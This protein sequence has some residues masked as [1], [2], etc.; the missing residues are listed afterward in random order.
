MKRECKVKTVTIS[1]LIKEFQRN[2]EPISKEYALKII[3]QLCTSKAQLLYSIQKATD[4][5]LGIVPD[6]ELLGQK[7][8]D[9]VLDEGLKII[10][11]TDEQTIEYLITNFHNA[12]L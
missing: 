10:N 5:N 3:R 9:R 11:M 12:D 7:I 6:R 8:R 2:S 1:G 4:L